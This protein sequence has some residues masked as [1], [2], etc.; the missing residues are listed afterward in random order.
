VTAVGGTSL[1]VGA[2]DTYVGETGWSTAR[3]RLQYSNGSPTSWGSEVFT[4]GG[5]GGPSHIFPA[6]WYQSGVNTDNGMRTVP[7]ISMDGDPNTGMLEG[8]TQTFPDGSCPGGATV[9]YGQYRIGGTS[10]SCPLF[11]G[12]MALVNQ[13]RAN[14]SLPPLGFAN[15]AIYAAYAQNNGSLHDVQG[16]TIGGY[17]WVFRNDFLNTLNDSNTD[18]VIAPNGIITSK[19]TLGFTGQF[20]QTGPGYDDMTGVG[21]PDGPTFLNTLAAFT[22]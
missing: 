22:G 16:T 17:D 14:N 19:R 8:Q 3:S 5:G 21:S 7:D 12:V 2:G 10:V 9:C 13:E 1:G 4:G 6:P 15:P 11:A 20:I 18:P